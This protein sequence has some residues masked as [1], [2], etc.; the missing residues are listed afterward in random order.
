[1]QHLNQLNRKKMV[2]GLPKPTF[3]RDKVCET[4]QKGK[5]TKVSF[6]PKICVSTERPLELLHMDLFG[7]SRTMSLGVNFYALVIVY[8]Y[9]RFT[10][11]LFLAARN[12]TF[13]AFKM[14]L[15]RVLIRH[16]LKKTPYE[17]FKGRGHVLTHLKVLAVNSLF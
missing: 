3:E 17:C 10:W 2:E 4:C 14:L 13:H 15:N 8:D 6:K 11:T 1:M 16:T 5:Q 9:C 12:D 7:P